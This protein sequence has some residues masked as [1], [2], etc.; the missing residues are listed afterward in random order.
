MTRQTLEPCLWIDDRIEDAVNFWVSV[1]PDGKIIDVS[2]YGDAVPPSKGKVM[3]MTFEIMGMRFMALNG[4]PQ[5]TFSEAIS[6]VIRCE[7][8]AEVDSYWAKLTAHGGSEQACGWVRDRFGLSWQV[9]PNALGRLAGDHNPR[10][11]QAVMAAMLKMKKIE[12]AGLEQ[13]YAE[14]A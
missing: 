5:F 3:T 12:I 8:Q 14:A 4:G 6:F 1:F 11:A 9:V 2:R 10:K 7:T 13:A